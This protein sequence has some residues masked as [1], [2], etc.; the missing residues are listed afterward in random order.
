MPQTDRCYPYRRQLLLKNVYILKMNNFHL[1][2]HQPGFSKAL[3]ALER[4]LCGQIRKSVLQTTGKRHAVFCKGSL[5]F[6]LFAYVTGQRTG[7]N[8]FPALLGKWIK[9]CIITKERNKNDLLP[10]LAE[11]WEEA[12]R[13][14]PLL[15]Q[16]SWEAR[17]PLLLPIH[18]C[19]RWGIPSRNNGWVPSSSRLWSLEISRVQ[20]RIMGSHSSNWKYQTVEEFPP[21]LSKVTCWRNN[22]AVQTTL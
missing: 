21:A 16:C 12:I 19:I 3:S 9:E 8:H 7:K 2:H 6:H 13:E 20:K 10:L 11:P 17:T 1:G 18:S 14:T 5:G 4:C 22:V 15:C